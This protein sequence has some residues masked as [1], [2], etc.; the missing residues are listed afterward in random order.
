MNGKT[1]SSLFILLLVLI[2]TLVLTL[3][4][5]R[6]LE[7]EQE[8]RHLENLQYTDATLSRIEEVLHQSLVQ[9]LAGVRQQIQ[10]AGLQSQKLREMALSHHFAELVLIYA[11]DGERL[12][13]PARIQALPKEQV[14]LQRFGLIIDEQL[15]RLKQASLPLTL[16]IGVPGEVQLLHC[17][18]LKLRYCVLLKKQWPESHLS[19]ALSESGLKE[20]QYMRLVS[21]ATSVSDSDNDVLSRPLSGI[22]SN[23]RLLYQGPSPVIQPNL[24]PVY[25]AIL[26]PVVILLTGLGGGVYH[27]QQREGREYKRKETFL[28]LLAHELKTPLANLQLYADLIRRSDTK[29]ETFGYLDIFDAE[30]MRMRHLVNNSVGMQMLELRS[31]SRVERLDIEAFVSELIKP[32]QPRVRDAELELQLDFSVSEPVHISRMALEYA[33]TNLL[34]NA[35]KYAPSGKLSL[36]F[37][38][39]AKHLQFVCADGGSGLT[40]VQRKD[41]LTPSSSVVT[42]SKGFGLG[43]LVARALVEQANGTFSYVSEPQSCFTIQLPVEVDV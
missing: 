29:A 31:Q 39:V 32:F 5:L 16:T 24:Q 26:V 25:A 28:R 33:V 19:Q 27:M 35:I 13:P 41:L 2:P 15:E 3:F 18:Q 42:G 10:Q 21:L 9:P 43:L 20:A 36:C 6:A 17:W 40:A 4:G 11:A 12:F 7:Q 37:S 34:D 22:L 8:L 38:L 1:L 23:W 30:F 14:L